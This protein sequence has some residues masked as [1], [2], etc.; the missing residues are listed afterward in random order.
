MSKAALA[1]AI[2]EKH[3]ITKALA[4]DVIDTTLETITK[5]LKK[6]GRFTLPG[7]GSFTV[8]K[9]G[10]RKGRNPQTGAE[11]KIKASKSVGFRA[12]KPLK[13]SI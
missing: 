5:A 9:R 3:E 2:S 7:F 10:A 13:E 8:R 12:G 11:I 4:A 1:A 6:E